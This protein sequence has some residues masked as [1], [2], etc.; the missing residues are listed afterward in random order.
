[1]RWVCDFVFFFLHMFAWIVFAVFVLVCRVSVG[2]LA[3]PCDASAPPETYILCAIA[4]C[5]GGDCSNNNAFNVSH[6][7]NA[8]RLSNMARDIAWDS[9][10]TTPPKTITY[11]TVGNC[12]GGSTGGVQK[13]C[14]KPWPFN[15][16]LHSM[17]LI[18][19]PTD[20]SSGQTFY[21]SPRCTTS[22]FY[23]SYNQYFTHFEWSHKFTASTMMKQNVPNA[24]SL[25]IQLCLGNSYLNPNPACVSAA[26]S[27]P[28]TQDAGWLQ[29]NDNGSPDYIPSGYYTDKCT[30][31]TWMGNLIPQTTIDYVFGVGAYTGT[32]IV[33]CLPGYRVRNNAGTIVCEPDLQNQCV[34]PDEQN[35]R[36]AQSAV[37]GGHGT[38]NLDWG[39]TNQNRAL[40]NTNDKWMKC[41]CNGGYL[42]PVG[43]AYCSVLPCLD[44]DGISR[45]TC[46]GR[47]TCSAK[48]ASVNAPFICG[49]CNNGDWWGEVCQWTN[50]LTAVIG[51]GPRQEHHQDIFFWYHGPKT[52]DGTPVHK[53][54][55]LYSMTFAF[56][57]QQYTLYEPVSEVAQVLRIRDSCFVTVGGTPTAVNVGHLVA[58]YALP[59]GPPAFTDIVD[60]V[61]QDS[62]VTSCL[63]PEVGQ[64]ETCQLPFQRSGIVGSMRDICEPPTEVATIVFENN[65]VYCTTY[66]KPNTA[67]GYSNY[68]CWTKNAF[69]TVAIPAPTLNAGT[70]VVRCEFTDVVALWTI[71][72]VSNAKLAWYHT[73]N[74]MSTLGE[75]V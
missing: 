25:A 44:L 21:G 69:S 31:P 10:V 52:T 3:T 8:I 61:T 62:W 28:L 40:L 36:P 64:A 68:F 51:H 17:P 66:V 22:E 45:P 32:D 49:A 4:A 67:S 20:F 34:A 71:M 65:V 70:L 12:G 60:V 57:S 73:Y 33:Q 46:L 63:R 39:L 54:A 58:L 37:C 75:C 47:G 6:T 14:L 16:G 59:S 72:R 30:A 38:C 50:S 9:I 19:G 15:D 41:T 24:E 43:L 56:E 55:A 1:M 7:S 27:V 26:R 18:R 42:S 11:E 74:A 29:F 13:I 2:V 23:D 5:D 53:D 35:R 48:T